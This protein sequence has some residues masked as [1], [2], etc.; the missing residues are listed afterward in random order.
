MKI[1]PR[2]TQILVKPDKALSGTTESGLVRPDNEEKEKKA[3]GTVEAAGPEVKD[4]KKGYRVI[5]GQFA[6]EPIG[7]EQD[8]DDEYILLFDED[9]LAVVVEE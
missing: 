5:Y 4:V 9:V 1:I 8:K 3:I 7:F 6:G 2:K